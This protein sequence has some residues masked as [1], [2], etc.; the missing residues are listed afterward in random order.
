MS[1]IFSRSED[2]ASSFWALGIL[3]LLPLVVGIPLGFPFL[4]LLSHPAAWQTWLEADR[5]LLLLRD[6]L[7][8]TTGALTLA[9]PLGM[10]GATLLY[11]TDLP[12]RRLFRFIIILTLFVPLS[13]WVSSWQALLI[14]VGL[15]PV[16]ASWSQRMAA[17]IGVQAATSLPW[18]ILI[19]GQGLSWVETELEE[20]ALTCAHPWRV[21]WKVTFPRCRASLLTAG[22]WVALQAAMEITVTDAL[23]VRTFAE[24]VYLQM[25]LGNSGGLARAMAVVMPQVLL[26]LSLIGWLAKGFSLPPLWTRNAPPLLFKLGRWKG[27][28]VVLVLVAC[29]FFAFIS[30]VYLTWKVGL[31]GQPLAWHGATALNHLGKAVR[32]H[33]GLI[34]ASFLWAATSAIFIVGLGLLVCWLGANNRMVR[35]VA[36]ILM[37]T[38]LALPA[39]VIGLGLKSIINLLVDTPLAGFLYYGTSPA[40]N[41]WANLL[42]FLPVS[43]VILWPVVRLIPVELRETAQVDGANPWQE[44]RYVVLPLALPACLQACWAI[45]AMSLGEIAAGKPVSTPG[46]ETFAMVVFDRMHYGLTN[47]L[48]ALGLLEV[49][50]VILG[51]VLTW[52]VIKRRGTVT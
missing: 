5:L 38:A 17:A 3:L 25:V 49:G 12:Y 36:L 51:G 26:T 35:I 23:D 4:E 16:G 37:A 14:T 40:P 46:A 52:Q 50:G 11:K 7:L 34:L 42:R 24:E 22:L 31:A 18:V 29:V 8:F 47:D 15:L 27:F 33:G 30:L 21:L 6:T 28:F 45:L 44:L 32:L 2:P 20:D 19:V 39:P 9:L 41:L 1:R 10:A 13:L 48:A 43:L